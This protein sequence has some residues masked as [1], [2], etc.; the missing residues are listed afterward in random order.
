MILCTTAKYQNCAKAAF[1]YIKKI[2]ERNR[3]NSIK[4]GQISNDLRFLLLDN[5]Y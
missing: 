4:T 1:H 2:D 3:W 5:L